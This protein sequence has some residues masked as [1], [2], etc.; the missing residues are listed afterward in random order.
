MSNKIL[1]AAY[2]LGI[3]AD[4]KFG[5]LLIIAPSLCLSILGFSESLSPILRFWMAYSGIAIFTWTAFLIWAYQDLAE[6]KF[7]SLVTA[8]VVIGFVV[9]QIAAILFN[10]VPF[11]NMV[12]LLVLQASLIFAFVLGYIRA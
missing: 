7:V 6:R 2:I 3:I 10:V 1:K 8:F 4:I 9:A 5:L 11:L 12:P